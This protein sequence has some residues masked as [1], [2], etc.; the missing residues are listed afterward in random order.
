MVKIYNNAKRTYLLTAKDGDTKIVPPMGFSEIEDKFTGD[1]TYR[2]AMRAG[3]FTAFET[4]KQGDAAERS[5]QEGKKGAKAAKT[6]KTAEAAKA[7]EKPAEAA[8]D[9]K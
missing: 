2:A 5:A 7:E 1:I 4:A 8:A 9:A 6:D 3:D